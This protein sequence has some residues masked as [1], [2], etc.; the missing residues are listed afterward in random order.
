MAEALITQG[1]ALARR[2][3]IDRG[4]YVFRQAIEAAHQVNALNIADLPR[5]R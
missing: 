2:G 5:W 1:V 4:E 3:Q